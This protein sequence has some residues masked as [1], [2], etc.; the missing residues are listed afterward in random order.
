[1]LRLIKQATKINSLK[2]QNHYCIFESY[3]QS[4]FNREDEESQKLKKLLKSFENND[5]DLTPESLVQYL[6]RFVIGQSE[7]KRAIACAF[8]NRWRRR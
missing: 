4:E 1:M 3:A 7:A 6:D 5:S 2:H 8:R